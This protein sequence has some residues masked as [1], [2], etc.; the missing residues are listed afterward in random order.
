M[1][2]AH[3]ADRD[4]EAAPER[5]GKT[6]AWPW[7]ENRTIAGKGPAVSGFPHQACCRNPL[8]QTRRPRPEPSLVLGH[9]TA[10]RAEDRVFL[11]PLRAA[12]SLPPLRGGME[13]RRT[14]ERC[15]GQPTDRGI[16]SQAGHPAPGADPALRPRRPHDP[17]VY[18][19]TP[20]SARHHPL[21]RPPR[22][23]RRPPLLGG[24]V[25]DPEVPPRVPPGASRI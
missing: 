1:R 23:Q 10:A 22:G 13:G 5:V 16:V 14:R 4:I 15:A 12:R 2:Y 17:P 19:A 8:C 9:Y 20:R 18:R 24:T 11:L 3:L 7:R 6:M 25:P 21:P